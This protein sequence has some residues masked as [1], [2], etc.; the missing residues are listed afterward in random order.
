MLKGFFKRC[1]NVLFALQLTEDRF[2][3]R[4]VAALVFVVA[5]A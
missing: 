3:D 5:S 4:V 2:C 1:L